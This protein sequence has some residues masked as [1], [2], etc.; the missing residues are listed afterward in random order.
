[1]PSRITRAALGSWLVRSNPR[2][3]ADFLESARRGD[4]PIDRWCVA[5]NYRSAMMQSQD[6]I[7]LWVSGDG[8]RM[9]RG[10]W[11]AGR[12]T[13]GAERC[14]IESGALTVPV[15]IDLFGQGI[16]DGEL[17]SVGINDLEVQRQ[18][19]GSNPSWISK[20][21]MQEL[22]PILHSVSPATVL[23]FG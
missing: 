5:S 3:A 6:L 13:G 23:P 22:S 18:P 21:H 16:S 2:S 14:G 1:M 7:L 4:H 20:T 10:L 12:V 19:M 8:R 11:G 17:R 9:V 15:H